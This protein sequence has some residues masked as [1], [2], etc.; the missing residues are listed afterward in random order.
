MKPGNPKTE[1]ER[2]HHRVVRGKEETCFAPNAGAANQESQS[3]SLPE[4]ETRTPIISIMNLLLAVVGIF[5]LGIPLGVLAIIVAFVADYYGE[6]SALK[7]VGG[8]LGLIDIF[9][10]LI[11]LGMLLSMFR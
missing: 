1:K 5:I 11:V 6:K 9:L 8:V 7:W 3:H 4:T 10:A 2:G